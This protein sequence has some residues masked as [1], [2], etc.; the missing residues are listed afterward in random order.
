[1]SFIIL[2]QFLFSFGRG[3]DLL[4]S[5][6]AP[7]EVLVKDKMCGYFYLVSGRLSLVSVTPILII[8]HVWSA[9]AVS[10]QWYLYI[11][12]TFIIQ[13]S[14]LTI[15]TSGRRYEQLPLITGDT[16]HSQSAGEDLW[17]IIAGTTL[18]AGPSPPP[19]SPASPRTESWRLLKSFPDW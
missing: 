14:I 15:T 8:R 17:E 19:S 5:I 12:S 9:A 10:R 6:L 16:P 18:S 3:W 13:Q 2:I 11:R 1:M 7:G 4:F